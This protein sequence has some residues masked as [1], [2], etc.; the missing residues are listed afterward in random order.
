MVRT[1]FSIIFLTM[2]LCGTSQIVVEHDIPWKSDTVGMW[3]PSSSAWSIDQVDTLIDLEVGPYGDTYS[4]VYNF[5]LFDSVG[6]IFD[7]GMYF[8]AMAIFEMTGW[9]SGSV[10]VNYPTKI[11]MEFPNSGTVTNGEWFTVESDYREHDT[12]I[13]P[14][15]MDKWELFSTWPTAGII[16]LY[17]N[18]DIQA[19][20]D[21]IYSD[22]SNPFD[23]EWDTLHLFEPVNV[24]LDTFDIFLIDVPNAEYIIP[25][26]AWHDD[27]FGNPVI[28]SVY[29]LHDSLGWPIEFPDIFYELI[30]IS[31]SIEI[32]YIETEDWIEDEQRLYAW[33]S[34][35]YLHINL[36][37]VKFIQVMCHYLSNVP[38][39]A[40]LEQV[41]QMMDYEEGDTSIFIMTDPISGE[42]FSIT[43]EWD[44]LD[45]ELLFTNTMN[46]TLAFVDNQDYSIFG[47]PIGPEHY[48]NVWNILEFPEP[49]EYKVYDL[50]ATMIEE[51]T[52]DYI[53]YGA[54]Y[55]IDLKYPCFDYEELPVTISHSIDPWLTNLIQDTI[56]VDFYIKVLD[57]SYSIGTPSNPVI[58]GDFLAYLDTINLGSFAGPPLFGPPL[59]LPW[60]IDGY[61][62]DTTFIPDYLIEPDYQPLTIV[63]M[64]VTDILCFGE[65]T[66]ALDPNIV[67]GLPPYQ[68]EWSDGTSIIS[69]N[70][71]LDNV[72]AGT[73]YLTVT[74]QGA[75][76]VS[77]QGTIEDSS[78]P[79][80]FLSLSAVD[81]LCHGFNTGSAT[82]VVS[83]GTPGYTYLWSPSADVSSTASN[84]F[85]GWHFVTITDNIGCQ[86]N[87]SI[88]IDE[89][90]TY[91]STSL[92]GT[93]IS[94]FNG[95][96]GTIDLTAVDGIPNYTFSWSN[97][98][99]LE[100]LSGLVANWYYITVTDL[101]GCIT[102]DSIELTQPDLLV[103][104]IMVTPVSCFGETDGAA[105]LTISGGTPPYANVW[106]NGP[107][108][109]DIS[110][111]A[112]GFYTVTVTDFLGCVTIET[113]FIIQ[114]DA[115]LSATLVQTP[116]NCFGGNDGSI[117]LTAEGGTSPYTYQWSSGSH[118]EDI[119][120]L[121]S[122]TY[123]V[124]VTD[125]HDCTF[126][127]S[128]T[129]TQP[130]APLA[131]N[132]NL[133]HVL[134]YEGNDGAIDL[135]VSGGTVPYHYIWS[136]GHLI[137]D[138]A[139]LTVGT[140][141][142]TVVDENGC[143]LS[144]SATITQPY[145]LYISTG[146][147]V[148]LC[149]GQDTV[150]NAYYSV[151]GTPPVTFH[152]SNATVAPS[153]HI[154]PNQTTTY[155]VYGLDA[156]N[157]QSN[158]D[159]LTVF[160]DDPLS[161]MIVANTDT[162]C[163][164]DPVVITGSITGGG[165]S[166][167]S[168]ILND[169]IL[170]SFP[171]IY[172]AQSNGYA[173][174]TVWDAC[175]FASISDSV[176]IH[177]YELP[178]AAFISDI[179]SGC[180]PL[181]VQFNALYPLTGQE[182]FWDFDDGDVENLSLSHDPV[183]TF[184]SDDLYDVTLV[185]LS[186]EG[187]YN[188][189]SIEDMITVYPKPIASFVT[190]QTGISMI[191][192][193]V[194]FVNNSEG[195][196]NNY[197]SFGDGFNSEESDPSHSYLRPDDYNVQLIV[198]SEHYC[199][200][201]TEINLKVS[202]TFT[203]YAPTA[204]TPNNDGGNDKFFVR[205]TGIDEDNFKMIIYDRWGEKVFE[206]TDYINGWDG[207]IKKNEFGSTGTYSWLVLY[208]DT[209]GASREYGGHVT[210]IR[211]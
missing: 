133:T 173:T 147:D 46:Q 194:N 26:V 13:Y 82:A 96:D 160:V 79:E 18:V 135:Q 191:H 184:Y 60:E 105:D 9:H 67:G 8:N 211:K 22:F 177:T 58:E 181:T 165:G 122:G 148:H 27:A 199:L 142:V 40:A 77:D 159:Y 123:S 119:S 62:P 32:P 78:N 207:R 202:G 129:V 169:T 153:I 10:Y 7:Y 126:S 87:D 64:G 75:C 182:Y 30:G 127:S 171:V 66:G 197:W 44:L 51:G 24:D 201:T 39:L 116:V 70:E 91:V 136:N 5:G 117:D 11:E 74:D 203:F 131:I 14:G 138:I 164:G 98:S 52:S 38:Q 61:F 121:V 36:D 2:F 23:I 59:F 100:D 125:A 180:Q 111:L 155:F 19:N 174:I 120:N 15:D 154:S 200:D 208:K 162:V 204:F 110:N 4:F 73:Y 106:S 209:N 140:Y 145:P 65:S 156:N 25:W 31:G 185:I 102:T 190:S 42:D 175:D 16:R 206:T 99:H 35:E 172:N 167:Y 166:P 146:S 183:H 55:N 43:A 69:T 33:G 50:T 41:S 84:L 29:F 112:G 85:A 179:K 53:K 161:M 104:D 81:V 89:P 170:G 90:D 86:K 28:D 130:D 189:Y 103:A 178:S 118:T 132:F 56:D 63:D 83:G 108:T 163:P 150:L 101:N 152:W 57:I 72:P 144:S 107:T 134:C 20:A 17:L 21:V 68:Y 188:T 54:D 48:P 47:I 37:I 137:E 49:V 193:E 109:E 45:A 113:I 139:N 88:F 34:D 143:T 76:S 1:I 195:N 12:T 93:N 115:P 151:G 176:F 80:I 94:C 158:I 187:C 196:I 124:T 149:Y 192:P 114:P 210:L 95:N 157:C 3:G 205:G 186:S 141:T 128:I 71:V 168:V 97:G 92:T 6:V 198:E